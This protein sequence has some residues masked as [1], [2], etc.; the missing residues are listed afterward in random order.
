M[1]GRWFAAGVLLAP[2]LVGAATP[3]EAPSWVQE[4]STR[5]L[6]VYPGK[7]PAAVL[8]EEQRVT[9]DPS[10]VMTINTR[11]A[12]KILTHEGQREA[13]AREYYYAGGRKIKDLRAWLVA[14]NGFVKTFDKSSVSDLGFFSEMELYNDIRAKAIQASNPEVGAVFAYESEVEERAL[15]AQDEYLFQVWLPSLDSRYV[16]SLPPGWRA[17]GTVLNH[18]AVEPV[19]QGTS[20]TWELKDLPFREH[21][22]NGPEARAVVPR[23][24]VDIEPSGGAQGF[25]SN[26]FRSWKDVSRW[27]A[28]LSAGQD[29][30][31]PEITAKVKELTAGAATAYGKIQAIGSYVQRLKY[32]AIEMD[33]AHGGGYK[34]HAADVVFHKKY[35]DCK[36]KANLMVAMLRAAGVESHLLALFSGDRTFVRKEWPSP[37]QFNHMIVAIEVPEGTAAETITEA[38]GVGRLLIFDPTSETTPVGDLPWYEQGS[39]ALLCAG[40]RG[41]ILKMPVTKPDSNAIDLAVNAELAGTGDL[42]VSLSNTEKGQSA[43]A[44]RANHL[45]N[46]GAQFRRNV[47]GVLARTAKSLTIAKLDTN[48]NFAGNSFRL[49]VEFGSPSYAQLMQNRLLVFTP[50]VADFVMESFPEDAGREEPVVLRAKAY[51]KHVRVKLPAGFT[52]DEMPQAVKLKSDFGEFSTTY[53]QEAGALYMDEELTTEAVTVPAA[54]YGEVKKFFDT[55][56]GADRQQAVLAKAD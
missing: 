46:D 9:V 14:P 31:T 28:A 20:Y 30:L 12:I 35:G 17:R 6:P 7:V 8:L 33:Q 45:Y 23:L 50:S 10:G 21:E 49:T 54:E 15:F 40:D 36:D 16:L 47:E 25:S 22:K 13:A 27:H 41:G 19:I 34:P 24:G 44:V 55:F 18:A 56:T 4:V 42:A 29:E 38:P 53:R 43:D 11:R 5:K 1:P 52:V 2:L 32:V 39:Y 37:S 26:C 51:R 3:K 48:D